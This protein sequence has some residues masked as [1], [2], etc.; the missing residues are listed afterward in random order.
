[1]IAFAAGCSSGG[2]GSA[3]ST[4]STSPASSSTTKVPVST[5]VVSTHCT[6]TQLKV[7]LDQVDAG[8]GQVYVPIEFVNASTKSCEM[9]GFPGVSLLDQNNKQIGQPAT[10]EGAEG[11]TVTLAPN[12]TASAL[13]HSAN[14]IGGNGN[15]TP[16]ASAVRV[17]PPDNTEAINV[18]SE[19]VACGGMSISTVVSGISG[20]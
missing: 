20:R 2:S 16:K 7:M 14:D 6:S 12:G 1:M 9:R 8:A 13:L 4:T 17:Y 11:S 19:F 15:C 18:P 5:T 3:S 10:R